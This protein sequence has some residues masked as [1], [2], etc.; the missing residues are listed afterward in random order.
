MGTMEGAHSPIFV[1]VANERRMSNAQ[2]VHPPPLPMSALRTR[3][4]VV[5][6]PLIGRALRGVPSE[7]VHRCF[8]GALTID[9][10]ERTHAYAE[11]RIWPL[12]SFPAARGG[13]GRFLTA[14][15]SHR[16]P[17]RTLTPNRQ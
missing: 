12:W 8:A 3:P 6:S 5:P 10:R 7:P 16:R 13:S 11:Q 14:F 15:R 4:D 9:S 2:G 1:P 17:G